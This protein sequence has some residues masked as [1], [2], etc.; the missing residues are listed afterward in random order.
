MTVFYKELFA[1]R[2]KLKFIL[3]FLLIPFAVICLYTLL[4]EGGH[5]LAALAFGGRVV[6]FNWNFL[7]GRPHV[8]YLGNFSPFQQAVIN[9]A[10]PLF[11]WLVSL[12]AVPLLGKREAGPLKIG[13]LAYALSAVGSFLPNIVLPL[14]Y[15]VGKVHEGED[16]VKFIT[17]SGLHPLLVAGVFLIMIIFSL[18]YFFRFYRIEAVI[19]KLRS[20]LVC[21][22]AKMALVLVAILSIATGVRV[23]LQSPAGDLSELAFP[24][25]VELFFEDSGAEKK[26][27][28]A[29][30]LAEPSLF[31]LKYTLEANG[32][33]RLLL[34]NLSETEFWGSQDNERLIFEG[35]DTAAGY[36]TG[37][38]LDPA[39]YE[40]CIITQ[41]C[42]GLLKMAYGFRVPGEKDFEYAEIFKKIQQGT[43][44]GDSYREED[45]A[46]IYHDFWSTGGTEV[47][48]T[49]PKGQ[50][51]FQVSA[52]A[53]GRFDLLTLSYEEGDKTEILSAGPSLG[54]IGRGQSV[55]KEG[56]RL[57][58][59]SEGGA[60]EIFI[61]IRLG[62]P[63]SNP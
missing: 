22:E 23:I 24:N 59:S 35:T 48:Y 28:F 2:K 40:V 63:D 37:F 13:A 14:L 19:K 32:P 21:K 9:I 10:G 42:K 20:Y 52:F 46:L 4:H 31:D 17:N 6:T 60:G 18:W 30:D 26:Q 36:Y 16:V 62:F 43:F 53:Q 56:G 25:K 39:S 11:P 3:G 34:I 49:I 8:S 27:V 57:I 41:G 33:V 29:F 5:A 55:Q 47:V 54:T 44:A 7:T 12:M 45:Y 61:Y 38:L 50:T 51:F 15:A 1:L 58:L